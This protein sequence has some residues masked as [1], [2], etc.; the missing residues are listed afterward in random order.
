MSLSH[1][2]QRLF[3]RI[4]RR[5]A[6]FPPGD[7]KLFMHFNERYAAHHIGEWTY[8]EPQIPPGDDGTTLTM[9]KFCSI[10]SGVTIL[11]GCEHRMDWVS[12]YPFKILFETANTL[13]LPSRSKG[14]VT[15]GHDVWI[16]IDAL[17]LSGVTI[18]NGAV[19]GARAVVTHDVAPYSVVAGVPARHI[20]FRFDRA[21][22]DA[23]ERIA[24]WSWPLPKIEAALPLLQSGD[25]KSF[26]NTYGACEAPS[27][28][29]A[30]P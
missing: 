18:G 8:G 24:W 20:R 22:I 11:T 30:A 26:L 10:G 9:G 23:L 4:V 25:I 14:N 21:T 17:I 27:Q 16:G 3:S 19:I 6:S 13:P 29:E 28:P 7:P 5:Q 15:I 12:T 2:L 1:R